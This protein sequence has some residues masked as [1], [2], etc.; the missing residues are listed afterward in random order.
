MSP[1]VNNRRHV[2][3]YT[4]HFKNGLT[5]FGYSPVLDAI[6]AE[7]PSVA[8]EGSNEWISKNENEAWRAVSYLNLFP[9]GTH[10]M[11]H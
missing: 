7:R 1:F 9:E 10:I 6:K 4:T 2:P 3:V 5:Y 11:A 8:V